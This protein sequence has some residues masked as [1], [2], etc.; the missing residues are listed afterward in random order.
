MQPSQWE[1]V[2][3]KPTRVFQNF[4]ASQVGDENVPDYKTLVTDKTAYVIRKQATDEETLDEIEHHFTTMFR[5]EIR[6]WL[7]DKATNEIE[8]SFLDFLC[9]FKFEL[10]SQIVLMEPSFGEGK[11]L[12]RIKPRSV[13]LKWMKTTAAKDEELAD[14]LEGVNLSAISEN[15]TVVIKNFSELSQIKPFVRDCYLPVY[16]AEMSRMSDSPEQWPEVDSFETFNRYFAIEI[17]TQLIHL[18]H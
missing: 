18:H 11:Q 9:C 1:I 6:R 10:H 14:L 15:A 3:L 7:G 17:H 2:I 8:A 12:L 16:E 4:L 13:L 5:H